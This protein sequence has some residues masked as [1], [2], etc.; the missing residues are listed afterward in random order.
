MNNIIRN[1]PYYKGVTKDLK[2]PTKANELTYTPGTIVEADDLNLDPDVDCGAGINFCSTFAG[3]LRW[4]EGATVVTVTVP[5]G[6][7]IVDAGDKLRAKRVLVGELVDF[8]GADLKRADLKGADLKGADLTR[9]DLKG[10]DLTRADLKGADLKGADLREADLTRADLKDADLR[11]AD[12]TD[13]NFRDA[14]LKGA[15]LTGADLT[16][17]NFRDADLIDADLTDADLTD[18]DLT[19]ARGNHYTFLPKGYKVVDGY[20]VREAER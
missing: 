3:A 19:D 18:A 20:V 6:E 16:D 13:A 4:A 1:K 11:E 2:S 8:K 14:D 5:D 9:A 15:D 12:L 7:T 17:A 10:A